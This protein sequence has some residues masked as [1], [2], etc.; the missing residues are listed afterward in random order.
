VQTSK[1]YSLTL[2]RLPATPDTPQTHWGKVMQSAH[3]LLLYE[4]VSYFLCKLAPLN[5]QDD[6]Q[7]RDYVVRNNPLYHN[8]L[9]L[10]VAPKQKKLGFMLPYSPL[11]YLLLQQFDTPLVL[12]SG[13]QSHHPQII[14]NQQALQELGGI[15]DYFLLHNRDIVNRLDDS[16]VQ[17]CT[18]SQH[19]GCIKLLQ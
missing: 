19:Q 17:V 8:T 3:N 12:T 10:Q 7:Y 5:H 6:S 16:V 18:R 9:S 14:D 15:A 13:N 11:H 2:H 4:L 1:K